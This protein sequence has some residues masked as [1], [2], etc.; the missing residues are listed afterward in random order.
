MM[1][2][3]VVL[4]LSLLCFS[5]LIIVNVWNTKAVG[6]TLL[7]EKSRAGSELK[8]ARA[9]EADC[10]EVIKE[11]GE[12]LQASRRSQ[13]EA[14][15]RVKQA[16]DEGKRLRDAIRRTETRTESARQAAKLSGE[17]KKLQQSDLAKLEKVVREQMEEVAKLEME[18][19]RMT[20]SLHAKD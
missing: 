16:G 14:R 18:Q 3:G 8:I 6:Q 11:K 5:L 19:E 1:Q 7:E 13:Q 12:L 4:P 2:N 15:A 9:Q 10:R 17:G 20:K